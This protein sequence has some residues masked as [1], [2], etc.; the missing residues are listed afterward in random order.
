MD[1]IL[2]AKDIVAGYGQH[3]VVKGISL[4]ADSGEK[5]LIIG[6]NGCGKT[7]FLMALAGILSVHEGQVHIGGREVTTE[8][9]HHR[10]RLGLGYLMQT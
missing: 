7:T 2:T 6:P 9:C 10:I 8:P 4:S 1:K 3:K 5:V